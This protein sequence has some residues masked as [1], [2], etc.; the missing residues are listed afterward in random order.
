MRLGFF[1]LLRKVRRVP[2][3]SGKTHVAFAAASALGNKFFFSV[4]KHIRYYGIRF[5]VFNNR[6]ERDFNYNVVAAASET[7][8]RAAALAVARGIF[9]Y[10]PKRQKVVH[11]RICLNVNI[12]AVAAV[13]A[14][15]AAGGFAFVRLKRV[16]TVAAV[17]R[18]NSYFYLVGK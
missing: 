5:K 17:A 1:T 10:I 6:T 11:R 14:V 2:A 16:H 18:F 8:V 13:A 9:A 4:F 3:R 15:R 12:S 7:F